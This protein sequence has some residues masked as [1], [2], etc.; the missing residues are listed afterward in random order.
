MIKQFLLYFP[1]RFIFVLFLYTTVS[2]FSLAQKP[3]TEV[4]SLVRIYSNDKQF[5][6]IQAKGLIYV[7]GVNRNPDFVDA[8]VLRSNIEDIKKMC[9]QLEVIIEDMTTHHE[10]RANLEKAAMGK[11]IKKTNTS[12][13]APKK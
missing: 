8:E 12:P 11:K 13:I 2:S 6:A 4:Y 7:L 5:K 9:D 10:A 3:P 1:L